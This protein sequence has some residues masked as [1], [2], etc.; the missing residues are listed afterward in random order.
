MNTTYTTE[1]HE[2]LYIKEIVRVHGVTISIISDRGAQFTTNFWRSFQKSLGTQ[3]NLSTTFQPQTDGQA[4]CTIHT[5]ED[6][7]RSCI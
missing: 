6:M 4:E 5:L 1:E 3:V 7:M 2:T